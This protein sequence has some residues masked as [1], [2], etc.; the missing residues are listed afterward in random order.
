[1]SICGE[2]QLKV[3]HSETLDMM[4]CREV[5]PGDFVFD[6]FLG[7]KFSPGEGFERQGFEPTHIHYKGGLYQVLGHGKLGDMEMTIYVGVKGDIWARPREMFEG[8]LDDG[9]VRFRV[10]RLPSCR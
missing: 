4:F 2:G 6:G 1:M 7:E 9:Q 8:N 3:A 10:F 5:S